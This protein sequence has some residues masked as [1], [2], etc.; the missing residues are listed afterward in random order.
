[1]KGLKL[2]RVSGFDFY[3]T[4][5]AFFGSI[6][7]WVIFTLVSGARYDL[8]PAETAVAGVI[9][10][11]FYWGTEIIHQMGHAWASRRA[12]YPMMAVKTYALIF[13]KSIYPRDE[14]ELPA[15]V[16]IQRA[17]GGPLFN[18]ILAIFA[19]PLA[20]VT[21]NQ[22]GLVA[23][24]SFIFAFCNLYY[25]VGALTPLPAVVETDGNTILKWWGKRGQE[26]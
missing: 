4:R 18:G 22:G 2:F 8:T 10:T 12:G 24:T 23:W 5:T 3:V 17:F 19:V 16:H 1:M 25:S 14:G 6:M 7:L 20:I 13:G 15:S 21:D 26:L 9:G 11:A